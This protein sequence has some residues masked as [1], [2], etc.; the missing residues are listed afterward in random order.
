M[1]LRHYRLFGLVLRSEL[2]LPE[3]RET[4]A[5]ADVTIARAEVPT[6]DPARGGL[7]PDSDGTLL[8]MPGVVRFRIRGGD[9]I[10]VDAD[11]A[12]SEGN[13]RLY[14]LGSAMGVILHQRRML[15]LHANAIDISG[16][17]IAFV[18]RSGAGKSTLAAA[19][20][21]RGCRLLSDDICVVTRTPAG[22]VEAQPGIPRVRLRRDAVERSGRDADALDEAFDGADK[23]VLPVEGHADAPLPLAAIYVLAEAEDFAIRPLGGAAATQ[24]LIANTYRSAYVPE[25]GDPRG[26]FENC[27]RLARQVP[28]FALERPWDGARLGETVSRIEAHLETLRR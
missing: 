23:Y 28:M 6:A 2:P 5:P 1:T 18:G 10:L 8:Q 14:L 17:A 24:A 19:F 22:V 11:P 4:D 21:D 12:A 15:P 13:I 27:L 7:L 9:T 25:I 16:Q 20:H 3:L 26:H